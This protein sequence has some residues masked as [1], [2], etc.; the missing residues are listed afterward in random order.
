ME[1]K[2]TV[3]GSLYQSRDRWYWK[4]KLPGDTNRKSITLSKPGECSTFSEENAKRLAQRIW[5]EALKEAK[6]I[7]NHLKIDSAWNER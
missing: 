3:Q 2:F 7:V 1:S 4:V 6:G 5:E